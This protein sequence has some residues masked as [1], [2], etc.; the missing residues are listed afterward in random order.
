VYD[1]KTP[2]KEEA[3]N[4]SA[5]DYGDSVVDSSMTLEKKDDFDENDVS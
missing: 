5:F 1:I 3:S 4:A 2:H